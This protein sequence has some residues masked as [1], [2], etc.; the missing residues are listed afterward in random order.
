MLPTDD[1]YLVQFE[2]PIEP[3]WREALV[4]AGAQIL[5]Y[6]PHFAFI[7]KMDAATKASVEE[8]EVVRW[9]GPYWPAYRVF[10]H[11]A[12][13][14][15]GRSDGPVRLIVVV[16]R[17]EDLGPIAEQLR[18]LGGAVLKAVQS[19]WKSKIQIQI[20]PSRVSAIARIPGV[21][22]IEP[23]PR[24]ELANDKADDIL[25]VREVWDT[26]GLHGAGQVVAV[27][28]TGL[29]QGSASPANLHDDFEDGL[30]HSLSLIHI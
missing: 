3:T 1:Y 27:C 26:H 4:Q 6:V 11:L 20:A 9:V 24:W 14:R 12:D 13:V 29:D 19:E 18:R 22:W 25:G 17:G 8:M 23:S 2:G 5:A 21:E 7:V 10:P 30:G 16:F 15:A 28:D